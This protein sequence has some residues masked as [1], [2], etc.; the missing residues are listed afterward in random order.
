MWPDL[1]LNVNT[2]SAALSVLTAMITPALLLSACGTFILSTSNRLAR[3]TDRMRMIAQQVEE[4]AKSEADVVFKK[5]R[6]SL[7]RHQISMQGKR[8]KLLQHALTLLYLA[9]SIIVCASLSIGLV[10]AVSASL[11][12]IPVSLGL[13]G[14]LLFLIATIILLVETQIAVQRVHDETA[15]LLDLASHYV[16]GSAG[17]D[18]TS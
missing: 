9:A 14:S 16:G 1:H 2:L 7:W 8:L 13:S 10:T 18:L 4:M 11:Y 3:V 17:T 15:L 12:W 5:E 6:L